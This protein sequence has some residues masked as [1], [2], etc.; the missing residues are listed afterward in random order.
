MSAVLGICFGGVLFAMMRVVSTAI[1]L[2]VVAFVCATLYAI[3]K[4]HV[5]GIAELWIDWFERRT[6]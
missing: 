2:A 4:P 5:I 1:A 3:V 6:Q